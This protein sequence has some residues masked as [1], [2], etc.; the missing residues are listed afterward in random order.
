MSG[1]LS[2]ARLGGILGALRPPGCRAAE[3][4]LPSLTGQSGTDPGGESP[5]VWAPQD[6]ATGRGTR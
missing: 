5:E 6:W 3:P 2:A 1:G 4:C